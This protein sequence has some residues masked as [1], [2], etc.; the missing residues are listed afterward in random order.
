MNAEAAVLGACLCAPD[1]YWKVADLLTPDDFANGTYSRLFAFIAKQARDGSEFDAVSVADIDPQLGDVALDLA[2]GEGWRTSAVRSYAELVAGNAINRRVRQA[3]QQIARLDGQDVLGEAQRLIG[4][5]APRQAGSVKHIREFLR[6]SVA[7]IQR[8]VNAT[9][10]LIGV[11]TSLPELD[12]MTCGWQRGDLI[13]LAAR[14]SVGKTAFAVQAAIAA[15][16]AKHGVLFMSLEMSGV[17]LADRVQAHVARVNA[18]GLRNPK[19]LDEADFG[20]LFSAAAEIAELPLQIDE[21]SG[22]T[23]DAICARAR[24]VNATQRLGLIVID[25]RTQIKPP[26]ADTTANAIQEIT[27]A[28]KGLAKELQVPILL[29]SQLNREG[30]GHRPT[31]RTLRDSGA[32]EQ[33]AD[34]ILFLHRP[35][36]KNREYVELIVAKQRN[37][38]CGDFGLFAD[39]PHMSFSVTT[40]RPQAQVVRPAFGTFASRS[41]RDE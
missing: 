25:Y 12:E 15:A 4:A 13:I 27:R 6:E 23:V 31:M 29:L 41:A 39:L 28:L 19:T 24:Q 35:D 38:E 32:I 11:T 7:E 10:A 14:P 22:L 34:V 9:E 18:H 16:K 36:D 37:G 20:R 26:K 21:T 17:Q 3:G 5:C 2:N 33:D 8:R 1:C 30:E 40:D